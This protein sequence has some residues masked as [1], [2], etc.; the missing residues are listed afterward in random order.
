MS[1]R[2]L[3][4]A[5]ELLEQAVKCG[6]IPGGVLGACGAD[7]PP[8]IMVAGKAQ[9]EPEAYLLTDS[10]WFDLAS[11][12]KPLVTTRQILRLAE[13]GWLDLDDPLARHLPEVCEV[14]PAAPIRAVTL[15][16]LLC[17]RSGLQAWHPFHAHA[18]SPAHARAL[19]TQ[20]DWP[21]TCAATTGPVYSDLGFLFLGLVIERITDTPFP[22]WVL[23][24]GLTFSPEP[25][26]CAATEQCVWRGKLLRGEVHDPNAITFGGAAGH[27]GLFGTVAGVLRQVRQILQ[28]TWA[29]P[30]AI[31]AMSTPQADTNGAWGLGWS[32]AQPGWQGGSL[33]SPATIGHVG[34][35]GTGVWVDL[36]RRIG[37]CL[38]TNRI[39]PTRHRDSGIAPLRR[40]I[41]NAVSA[42]WRPAAI[43]TTTV[44]PP[45]VVV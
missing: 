25:D 6:D 26:H 40:A 42:G 30:A 36:E 32:L 16:Q 38:L 41:G 44:N 8:E 17:H 27:A 14:T 20:T 4:R 11:L 24:E 7:G 37:W 43:T 3:P 9:R 34:F 2:F 39:H 23:D 35:T 22:Q 19:L 1:G 10:T 18:S 12:T 29:S 45:V 33:C 21:L 15:R 5:S 13:A 31:K 28:G